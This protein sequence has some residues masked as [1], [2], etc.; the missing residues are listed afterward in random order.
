MCLLSDN[1]KLFFDKIV[2][3]V[4]NEPQVFLSIKDEQKT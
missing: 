4:N 1:L 3:K 2:K